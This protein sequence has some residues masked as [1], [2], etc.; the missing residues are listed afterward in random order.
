MMGMN[1][2]VLTRYCEDVF[3]PENATATIGIDFKVNTTICHFS[4]EE[5][6]P[7]FCS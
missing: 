4:L 5:P 7:G 6:R 1:D 2:S 3:E